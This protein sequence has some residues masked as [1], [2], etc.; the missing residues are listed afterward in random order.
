M[1]AIRRCGTRETHYLSDLKK[2]WSQI[3]PEDL[4]NVEEPNL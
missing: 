4:F 1:A 3:I 2:F